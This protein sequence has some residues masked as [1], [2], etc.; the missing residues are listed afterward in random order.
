MRW[1]LFIEEYSP[2]LQYIKWENNVV[3]DILP[4]VFGINR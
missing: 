4:V 2:D 3:A 1:R